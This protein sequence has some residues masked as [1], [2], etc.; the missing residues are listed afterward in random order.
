MNTKLTGVDIRLMLFDGLAP[1][2][3]L[4]TTLS[5]DMTP[6]QYNQNWF[7][8]STL[9]LRDII[10]LQCTSKPPCDLDTIKKCT[11]YYIQNHLSPVSAMWVTIEF[12][13]TFISL[14]V[15]EH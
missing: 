2:W 15:T 1:H 12:N 9:V 13:E 7:F 14:V 5:Q 3:S 11:N 6:T 10:Y 4:V 8:K